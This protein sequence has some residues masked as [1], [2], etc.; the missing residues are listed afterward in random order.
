[1]DPSQR[2]HAAEARFRELLRSNELAEPDRVEYAPDELTFF[3]EE[4][5]LAVI[6]ELDDSSCPRGAGAA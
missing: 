3:W 5:K 1:M 6:V 2:H 4:P